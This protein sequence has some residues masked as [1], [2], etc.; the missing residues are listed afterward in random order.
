MLSFRRA[1]AIFFSFKKKRKE[2]K[3]SNPRYHYP[4]AG[5]YYAVLCCAALRCAVPPPPPSFAQ[6]IKLCAHTSGFPVLNLHNYIF[7]CYYNKLLAPCKC[8]V[9]LRSRRSHPSL[10]NSIDVALSLSLFLELLLL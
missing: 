4:G 8:S 1:V 9:S 10:F 3:S 7:T 5:C 6:C 2:K